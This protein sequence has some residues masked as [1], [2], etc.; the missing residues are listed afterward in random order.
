[1]TKD[2]N[3][4]VAVELG[5]SK[6]TAIAGR[7]QSDGAIQI[8]AYAQEPSSQFVRKGRINNLSKMT[9]CISDM[10]KKLETKLHKTITQTYVGIGC[11]GTHTIGGTVTRQLGD[12]VL[13]TADMVD[14]VKD[15]N[16]S[17]PNDDHIILEVIPQEYKLGTQIVADPIGM[18]SDS[19]EGHFLNIITNADAVDDVNSCFQKA[20]LNVAG[21]PISVLSLADAVLTESEKR[22]GCVF[23]DMGAQTTSIAIYKN[24]ILRHFA[25]IPLGG[26]NINRDLCN[27]LQIEDEEAETLK[28]KYGAACHAENNEEHAPLTLSHGGTVK[29]E[30]FCGLV[31]AR[32]EEIIL[33][34]NRQI[35]L[36]HYDKSLLIAGIIVTGGAASIKRIDKAFTEFIGF[37]KLRFTKNIRLQYR[38]DTKGLASFNEDGSFNAAISIVDKGKINC[39]G[40]ESETNRSTGGLFTGEEESA[41]E[42]EKAPVV[43]VTAREKAENAERKDNIAKPSSKKKLKGYW[44]KV[45]RWASNMVS[46]EEDHASQWDNAPADDASKGA[47]QGKA[48]SADNNKQKK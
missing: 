2:D 37:E 22:A 4:I 5:S 46:E 26:A 35:E 31:E 43:D 41:K 42:E 28:R 44:T 18:A 25:V 45:K 32:M 39:C 7:K 6:I 8:L 30:D 9:S 29:Y 15:A 17:L 40:G 10:K 48:T 33:N 20:D 12:K 23:V 36:S 11:M 13:I 21:K 14:D 3:F 19:I 47:A 16:N 34:I 27:T 1:M 38:M 24:N